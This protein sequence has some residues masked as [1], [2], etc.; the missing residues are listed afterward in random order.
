M[1]LHS[2]FCNV[3]YIQLQTRTRFHL[4]FHVNECS[5][6]RYSGNVQKALTS[7]FFFQMV[8]TRASA[9]AARRGREEDESAGA[10]Q[11]GRAAD[12]PSGEAQ[13][14][15]SGSTWTD[16]G[17]SP[18]DPDGARDT[19]QSDLETHVGMIRDP[20]GCLYPRVFTLRAL[21]DAMLRAGGQ[22]RREAASP[23]E[24]TTGAPDAPSNTAGWT[25]NVPSMTFGLDAL[26]P[27][28]VRGAER[29]TSHLPAS[30]RSAPLPMLPPVR[31]ERSGQP[32]QP[33]P[34][35]ATTIEAGPRLHRPQQP[36]AVD[37]GI[38]KVSKRKVT[39]AG[40]AEL[41]RIRRAIREGKLRLEDRLGCVELDDQFDARS[42]V[43]AVEKNTSQPAAA[44]SAGATLRHASSLYRAERMSV[45]FVDALFQSRGSGGS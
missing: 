21:A 11:P 3:E 6:Y 26:S 36:A 10:D 31:Q 32:P 20:S 44:G 14:E 15:E 2:Y 37:T 12:P 42:T 9:R 35:R 4:T 45:E 39:S 27:R 40:P 33:G 16:S 5:F 17:I 1:I 22:T 29:V 30:D 25:I 19:R 34:S 28:T 7:L 24:V 23:A 13:A 38:P 41:A 43:E 18:Q 8:N